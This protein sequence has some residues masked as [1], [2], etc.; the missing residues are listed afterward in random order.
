MKAG[1]AISSGESSLVA[2]QIVTSAASSK[3]ELTFVAAFLEAGVLCTMSH[4]SCPTHPHKLLGVA[5]V[6]LLCFVH[7]LKV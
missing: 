1:S 4:L 5:P 3:S 2:S 6:S 7:P